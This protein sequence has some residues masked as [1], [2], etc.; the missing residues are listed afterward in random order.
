MKWLLDCLVKIQ[1]HRKK[2][3]ESMAKT[4]IDREILKQT[5]K[6][7]LAETLHEEREFLHNIFAEVFEDFT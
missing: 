7:A 6:E 1:F 3:I 5:L 4:T 2:R